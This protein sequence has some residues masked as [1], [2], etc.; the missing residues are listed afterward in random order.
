MS[1]NIQKLKKALKELINTHKK[2]QLKY[3]QSQI[4]K[5]RNL[6]EDR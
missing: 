6:V 4:D 3:I 1:T 5:I 2:D